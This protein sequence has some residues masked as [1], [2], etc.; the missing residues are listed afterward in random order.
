MTWN[1]NGAEWR[2]GR[3]ADVNNEQVDIAQGTTDSAIVYQKES[4]IELKIV[5]IPNYRFWHLHAILTTKTLNR[6]QT[7]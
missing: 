1:L 3:G 2:I 6:R 7:R 4:R 5:I